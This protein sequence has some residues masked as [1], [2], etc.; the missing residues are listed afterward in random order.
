MFAI[1][2]ASLFWA[3]NLALDARTLDGIVINIYR[4]ESPK[5]I[6]KFIQFIDF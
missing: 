6:N 2:N 1:R 5:V 4:S 3:A